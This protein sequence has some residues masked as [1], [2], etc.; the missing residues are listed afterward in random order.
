MKVVPDRPAD[1]PYAQDRPKWRNLE[2]LFDAVAVVDSDCVLVYT[3]ARFR[4]LGYADDEKSALYQKLPDSLALPAECYEAIMNA[5]AGEGVLHVQSTKFA[6]NTGVKGFAQVVIDRL[7][8][9]ES[10]K[11]FYLVILKDITF[12][13][14]SREKLSEALRTI[15]GLRRSHIESQFLWRL[16]IEATN[17]SEP[18]VVFAMATKRL[19]EDLGFQDAFFLKVPEKN[20]AFPEPLVRDP[21]IGSRIREV[22]KPLIPDLRNKQS[23]MEVVELEDKAFGKFWVLFVRPRMEAPFFLLAR[24]DKQNEET[25]RRPFLESLGMQLLTWLDGRGNYLTNSTDPLTGL[26]NRH[27]FDSRFE[28]ECMLAKHRQTLLSLVIVDIDEFSKVN[29]K[30]GNM[31]GDA[32]LKAVASV[33]RTVVRVSDILARVGGEEFAL[34]LLDTNADDARIVAEKMRR[35][36]EEN[37]IKVP[38]ADVGVRVTISCGI[39][40]YL[41]TSA[42]PESIYARA[43]KALV[44][45]KERGRNQVAI[46]G[47]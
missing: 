10:G 29:L 7:P 44:T 1:S 35:H 3:N 32:V 28:V 24:S 18:S 33:L 40:E 30:Y 8:A 43:D 26:S 37:P 23:R 31:G 12:E 4:T 36:V 39:A 25:N 19:T 5:K 15:A 11:S 27:H 41:G 2:N 38:G 20:D 22:T 46:S 42:T 34:I 45:A 6:F 47:K 17:F 21:R 13:L 16:S 14:E 9:G